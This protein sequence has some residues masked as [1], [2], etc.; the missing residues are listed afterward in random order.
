MVFINIL[1]SFSYI[2]WTL[3]QTSPD[4]KFNYDGNLNL[5][6]FLEIA[7]ENDLLVILRTG[8]YMDAEWDMVPQSIEHS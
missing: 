6:R 5:F 7:Q 4:L 1:L 3:H 2:P 8:P